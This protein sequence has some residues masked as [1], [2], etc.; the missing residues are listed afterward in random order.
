MAKRFSTEVLD[1]LDYHNIYTVSKRW[2]IFIPTVIF[3]VTFL[4]DAPFGRFSTPNSPLALDGIRSWIF[5]ELISPLSF[6]LTT[7]IHPFSRNSLPLPT[8]SSPIPAPQTLLVGLYFA[9]YLNRA[10]LRPSVPPPAHPRTPM[11]TTADFLANAYNSPLFWAGLAL[12]AIGFAGNIM[13]DEIL[14]NIRRRATVKGKAKARSGVEHYSIPDGLLYRYISYPNYF[15]EWIEWL[16]FA[17]AAAPPPD[18]NTVPAASA[19]L[20]A[21]SSRSIGAVGTLFVPFVDSV[22][23]PWAFLAAEVLLMLPRA[24]RGHQWYLRR[25]GDAYPRERRI[26]V[27][28]LL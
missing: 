23:P 18:L 26:V 11:S 20:H 4:Y 27:P 8:I 28:F 21:I 12:W 5:M 14:L 10:I 1:L 22:A 9:H 17:L 15:C 2:F 13:H 19:V 3:P 6:L 16:G 7:I 25:F 24:V